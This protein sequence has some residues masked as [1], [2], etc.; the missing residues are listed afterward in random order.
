MRTDH[1]K[2]EAAIPEGEAGLIS[3][4]GEP[5]LSPAPAST[6]DAAVLSAVFQRAGAGLCLVGPDNR[7]AAANPLWFEVAGLAETEVAGRLIHEVLSMPREKAFPLYARA[8]AGQ[9]VQMPRHSHLVQG[10]ERWWD[11]SVSPVPMAGGTGILITVRDIS[12]QV[13]HERRQE[14][15]LLEVQRRASELD[16]VIESIGDGVVIVDLAGRILRINPAGLAALSGD[17]RDPVPTALD[18]FAVLRPAFL[19]GTP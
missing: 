19:D 10:V 8:R 11:G 14:E 15:L 4:W 2:D 3:P 16:A 9:T 17:S 7:V 12:D 13:V 18:A 6:V 5:R 1:P